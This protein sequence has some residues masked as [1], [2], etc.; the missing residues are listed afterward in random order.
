MWRVLFMKND[1]EKMESI[2]EK[3]NKLKLKQKLIEQEIVN[4]FSQVLKST[5]AFQIDFNSIVG[6]LLEIIETIRSD[7]EKKEAWKLIGEEFCKRKL[8]VNK[9]T[10]NKNELRVE[11]EYG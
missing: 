8:N 5:E 11:K 4:N 9:K 1:I 7:P 6:G 3:I 10:S 2:Q